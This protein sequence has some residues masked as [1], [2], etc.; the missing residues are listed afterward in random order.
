[1]CWH[2]FIIVRFFF[3]Q[4]YSLLYSSFVSSFSS[5]FGCGSQ[6]L[7]WVQKVSPNKSFSKC[8][9]NNVFSAITACFA[10]RVFLFLFPYTFLPVVFINNIIIRKD[11]NHIIHRA[12]QNGHT[13]KVDMSIENIWN[14]RVLLSVFQYIYI[15]GM[16]IVYTYLICWCLPHVF[17]TTK[18][19][20][21]TNKPAIYCRIEITRKKTLPFMSLNV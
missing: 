18:C 5:L 12:I 11:A 13:H 8:K 19:G 2:L 17:K 3:H 16:Y 21:K 10:C 7:L 15:N 6:K 1:M 14:E 4:S 20:T 9:R